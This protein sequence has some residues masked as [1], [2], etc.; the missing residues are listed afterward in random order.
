MPILKINLPYIL[1]V[2]EP[3]IVKYNLLQKP[4]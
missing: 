3:N 1:K 4:L 2:F